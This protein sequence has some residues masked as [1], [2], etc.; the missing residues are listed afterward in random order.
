MIQAMQTALAGMHAAQDQLNVAAENIANM[1]S[2]GGDSGTAYHAKRAEQYTDAFGAPVVVVQEKQPPTL[3]LYAPDLSAANQD[4]IVEVPN[5]N[6]A[7]E[8]VNIKQAEISYRA[9]IAVM[10]TAAEMQDVLINELGNTH[11]HHHYYA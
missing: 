6:L 5:V 1:N 7:E 2:T 3:K 8:I 10:K 9:S 4:G 11:H